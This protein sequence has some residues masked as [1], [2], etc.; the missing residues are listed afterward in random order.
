MPDSCWDFALGGENQIQSADVL[1]TRSVAVPVE[2]GQLLVAIE[3]AD[4]TVGVE[5]TR[6]RLDSR[7]G[8]K[9][10]CGSV[11]RGMESRSGNSSGTARLD[12]E[13]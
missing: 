4:H 3:L 8:P 1:I 12:I 6:S 5:G 10:P 2:L 7:A 13:L 11:P 9:D